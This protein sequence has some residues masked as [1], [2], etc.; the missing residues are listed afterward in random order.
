MLTAFVIASWLDTRKRFVGNLTTHRFNARIT[1]VGPGR[2]VM[3]CLMARCTACTPS[4][5]Y[6]DRGEFTDGF[7]NGRV[8]NSHTPHHRTGWSRAW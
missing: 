4:L 2:P 6:G 1:A 8:S 5:G 3:A 7:E